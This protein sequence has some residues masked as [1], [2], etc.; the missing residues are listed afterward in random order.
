MDSDDFA[1]IVQASRFA[2][3]ELSEW[4]R[5]S[6]RAA[7]SGAEEQMYQHTLHEAMR[8]L[9]SERAERAATTSELSEGIERRG[10][11]T[12]KDGSAAR[13]RKINARAR[14]YPHLFEIDSHGLVRLI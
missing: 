9:L 12:R 8:I 13:A 11:Y 4:V 7:A 5:D 6:L 1:L 14:K 2:K 10:L 3:K